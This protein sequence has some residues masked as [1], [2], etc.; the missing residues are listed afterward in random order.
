MKYPPALPQKPK[1]RSRLPPPFTGLTIRWLD[2]LEILFDH[3]PL[4]HQRL[5][6][7]MGKLYIM[8]VLIQY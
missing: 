1:G 3:P 8:K 2:S 6:L 7:L 4:L 5:A